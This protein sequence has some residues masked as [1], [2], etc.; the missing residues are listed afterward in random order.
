M[1]QN[2]KF[3]VAYLIIFLILGFMIFITVIKYMDKQEKE[4]NINNLN[5]VE[6]VDT[7]NL[8]SL[9][10]IQNISFSNFK[11]SD[12]KITFN[13]EEELINIIGTLQ[14]TSAEEQFVKLTTYFFDENK[15]VI[16]KKTFS[17]DNK[18][19]SKESIDFFINEYYKELDKK[20]TEVKYYK[21]VMEEI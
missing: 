2:I 6:Q 8:R 4:N 14:N 1:K 19:E 9:T 21:I 5:K 18:L 11:L 16:G 13:N 7:K 3:I 10:N 20:H 17:L 15:E 12:L